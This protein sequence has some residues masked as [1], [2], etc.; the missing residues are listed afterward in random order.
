[1]GGEY[2]NPLPKHAYD[3]MMSSGGDPYVSV[4]VSSCLDVICVFLSV[5]LGWKIRT[6]SLTLLIFSA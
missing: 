5:W 3:S 4:G 1:M 2:W 6:P